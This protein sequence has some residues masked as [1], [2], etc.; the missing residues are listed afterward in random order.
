MTLTVSVQFAT[1]RAG[2][3][4]ARTLRRWARAAVPARGKRELQLTI[5]FVSSSEGRALN[6]RWRSRD[7]ATNVLSFPGA[8][9][10]GQTRWLGD[11]VVCASVLRREARAQGK[12]VQGHCAHLVVHGVLHLLGYDHERD[13]D[14]ERMERREAKILSMLGYDDPYAQE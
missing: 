10:N 6:K 4:H 8:T 13:E 9:L 12:S 1:A 2:L 3:P 14:A 7:Y 11:I 5:R